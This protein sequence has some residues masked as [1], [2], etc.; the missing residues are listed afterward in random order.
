VAQSVQHSI[1]DF[2]LGHD[3]RVVGLSPT[4]G[5]TL[6]MEPA[7]DSLPL[8]L[9]LPARSLSVSVSLSQNKNQ[10][11]TFFCEDKEK[12]ELCL[13]LYKIK[14]SKREDT[15]HCFEAYFFKN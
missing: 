2:G 9:P 4:L 5:S 3:L 11:N 6:S 13:A 14:T 10:L 1:L 8:P 7:W 12:G 15:M